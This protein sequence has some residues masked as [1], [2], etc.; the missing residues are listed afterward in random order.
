MARGVGKALVQAAKLLS[1]PVGAVASVFSKK[2]ALRR[3]PTA[4]SAGMVRR[5]YKKRTTKLRPVI[6]ND[7]NGNIKMAKKIGYQP[8]RLNKVLESKI[9]D[10]LNPANHHVLQQTGNVNIPNGRC[11]YTHFE[12][13]NA[14]DIDEVIAQ[15]GPSGQA[16]YTSGKLNI[17]NAKLQVHLRNQT[18]NLVYLTIYEYICRR[19]VPDKIQAYPGSVAEVDGNTEQVIRY[20]YN[21]QQVAVPGAVSAESL[22]GTLYQNP[23]FCS[24]YKIV[25]VRKVMLGAGKNMSLTLSNLRPRVIN[26]LVYN[27]TDG[28]VLAG[29]T[30]GFAIQASG[31]LVSSEGHSSQVTTGFVNFDW[32]CSRKYAWNQPYWGNSKNTLASSVPQPEAPQYHINEFTGQSQIQQES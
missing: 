5:Y 9:R 6:S 1:N 7:G 29:L 2:K 27:A 15:S 25:R 21:Y 26:P 32:F 13:M 28:D 17:Q 12:M 23:M 14:E 11:V 10:I 8:R 20:G 16:N 24:Y 22:G 18:T 4:A 19:D 31:A 30:R 3:G